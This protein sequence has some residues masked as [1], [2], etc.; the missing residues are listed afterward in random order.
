MGVRAWLVSAV[1]SALAQR[2]LARVTKRIV[3]APGE[4]MS[5]RLDPEP[6]PR[7]RR[8]KRW[9]LFVLI[10]FLAV[11]TATA[12]VQFLVNEGGSAVKE[13]I[14]NQPP[15]RVDVASGGI[16][17]DVNVEN[18][19]KFV[20]P[21]PLSDIPPPPGQ[22][23]DPATPPSAI[24]GRMT[25]AALMRNAPR[26]TLSFKADHQGRSS[27]RASTLSYGNGVHLCWVRTSLTVPLGSTFQCEVPT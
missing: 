12:T 27:L 24:S 16:S 4:A 26:L 15:I 11:A 19:P 10:P 17:V 3:S 8:V 18:L 22:D 23:V 5:I 20:I 13:A 7:P 1:T 25:W 21:R 6:S 14:D 2:P 9:I